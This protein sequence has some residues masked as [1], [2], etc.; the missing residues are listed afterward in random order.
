MVMLQIKTGSSV[1][2]KLSNVVFGDSKNRIGIWG[3]KWYL[4]FDNNFDFT[5]M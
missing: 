4:K 1:K 2:A 3:Q 5:H